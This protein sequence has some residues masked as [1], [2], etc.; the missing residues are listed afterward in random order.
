L[1][2]IADELKSVKFAE[3]ARVFYMKDIRTL[4]LEQLTEYFKE[5]AKNLSVRN[6]F[7]IGCGAKIYI[8]LMK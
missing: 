1:A 5:M 6:R 4:T 8:L 2:D 7:M 3:S